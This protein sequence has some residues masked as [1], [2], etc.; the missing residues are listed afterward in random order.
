MMRRRK[1]EPKL[2]FQGKSSSTA[3]EELNELWAKRELDSVFDRCFT[4]DVNFSIFSS[5]MRALSIRN[6]I[7]KTHM[8]LWRAIDPLVSQMPDKPSKAFLFN[9]TIIPGNAL[10]LSSCTS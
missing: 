6:F 9:Q 2:E 10:A 1:M 7:P 8:E 5:T 4:D 3:I